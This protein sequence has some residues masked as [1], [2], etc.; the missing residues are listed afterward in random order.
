MTMKNINDCNW[1]S[2]PLLENPNYNK[3]KCKLRGVKLFFWKNKIKK[4]KKNCIKYYKENINTFEFNKYLQTKEK[5]GKK[6][7]SEY[8]RYQ[9]PEW[10]ERS[11]HYDE[12]VV[13]DIHIYDVMSNKGIDKLIK[14]LYSLPSKKFSVNSYYKKSSLFQRFDYLQLSYTREGY[15]IFSKVKFLE[16][17]YIE[18]LT[19]TWVQINNYYALFDYHFKFKKVL[20]NQLYMDFILDN[21]DLINSKDFF[22]GYFIDNAIEVSEKYLALEQMY[23]EFFSL[24]CQHYI[25]S[26]LF[27]ELGRDYQLINLTKMT[28]SNPI[29]IEKLYLGDITYSYYNKNENYVITSSYDKTNYLLYA[30]DNRIPNFSISPYI[31]RYGNDFYYEIFGSWEL[32]IFEREFSKYI[33]GRKKVTYN[34]SLEKLLMKLQSVSEKEKIRDQDFYENFNENWSYYISNNITDIRELNETIKIDFI[35]IYKENFS[36]LQV[37]SEINYTKSNHRNTIV[38]TI[39]AIISLIYSIFI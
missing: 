23:T 24:I 32:N 35:N 22:R 1:A 2:E 21:I 36:Y 5:E 13:S 26:L 14:K 12:Y 29:N 10:I 37:L 18:K 31:A 30:G 6:T 9:H 3:S 38:A 16:D 20:D 25:T 11:D 28:R 7:H 39:I 34:Q 19:I 27:S 15:G 33:T 8:I 4:E 17:K